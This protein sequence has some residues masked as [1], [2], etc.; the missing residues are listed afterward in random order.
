MHPV[1][2]FTV[3]LC[4]SKILM[5]VLLSTEVDPHVFIRFLPS[6][7]KMMF[8]PASM[9]QLDARPTGDQEVGGLT[10]TAGSILSWILIMKYFLWSFS[11]FC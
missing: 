1:T 4:T 9:A 2:V 5:F 10:P 7:V 3:F 8:L 6:H 11:P